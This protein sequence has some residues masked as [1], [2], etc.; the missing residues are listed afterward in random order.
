MVHA[1]LKK[2]TQVKL[3]SKSVNWSGL[4]EN[5]ILRVD[6]SQPAMEYSTGSIVKNWLNHLVQFGRIG[7]VAKKDNILKK[8]RKRVS[9]N[10]GWI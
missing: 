1:K 7:Y 5:I 2:E 8:N 3:C 6:Q 4:L 10:Y 9:C